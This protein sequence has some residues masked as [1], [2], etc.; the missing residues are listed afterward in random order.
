MFADE[1]GDTDDGSAA[2]DGACKRDGAT[3]VRELLSTS[4]GHKRGDEFGKSDETVTCCSVVNSPDQS[5]MDAERVAL[6]LLEDV[7]EARR[8]QMD[9]ACVG[10][11]TR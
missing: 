7:T 8:D 9:G 11:C 4:T 6:V 5:S 3:R 2:D 10:E 1:G